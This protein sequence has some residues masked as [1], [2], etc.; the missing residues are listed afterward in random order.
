MIGGRTWWRRSTGHWLQYVLNTTER[1]SGDSA[2]TAMGQRVCCPL[3][4]RRASNSTT[5]RL[6]TL[7]DAMVSVVAWSPA[8][9]VRFFLTN[10]RS[11]LC[12]RIVPDDHT[13]KA[14]SLTL[15]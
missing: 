7:V 1:S 12:P 9:H 6:S 13:S 2:T 4:S 8:S 14:L 5:A 15:V 3:S 10:S 11:L